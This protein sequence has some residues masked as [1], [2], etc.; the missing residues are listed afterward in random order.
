AV[1]GV[2]EHGLFLGMAN[3]V[4]LAGDDGLETLEA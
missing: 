4:I 1:P 2:V 3:T